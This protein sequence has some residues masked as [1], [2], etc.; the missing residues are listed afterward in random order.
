[1]KIPAITLN[2][3]I[4]IPVMGNGPGI[5]VYSANY[6]SDINKFNYFTRRLYNKLYREIIAYKKYI[7]AVSHSLKIGF[8]LLDFSA[9]YGNEQLIGK[10][11]K[12]SGIERKNLLSLQV[13]SSDFHDVQSCFYTYRAIPTVQLNYPCVKFVLLRRCACLRCN[14]RR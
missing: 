7:D 6:N 10:A 4:K 2:N 8:T 14:I 5:L 11:V 1:M 9:A 12:K 13:K 3:G